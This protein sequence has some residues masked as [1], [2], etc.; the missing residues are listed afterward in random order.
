LEAVAALVGFVAEATAT[1]ASVPPNKRSN[2]RAAAST[3]GREGGKI[4]FL[5][6]IVV[7][8]PLLVSVVVVE[9]AM[10]RAVCRCGCVIWTSAEG[11]RPGSRLT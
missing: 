6:V 10:V 3:G 11:R 1:A 5:A 7:G 9:A 8:G 4:S 2:L